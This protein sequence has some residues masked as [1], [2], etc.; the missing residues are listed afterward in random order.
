MLMCDRVRGQTLDTLIL[1]TTRG[2]G[3]GTSGS[4]KLCIME[5][6]I[7]LLVFFRG[8]GGVFFCIDLTWFSREPR[9]MYV[10]SQFSCSYELL[11]T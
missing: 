10:Y 1:V 5:V 8:H 4:M 6:E 11:M 2:V 9:I 3:L 7:R